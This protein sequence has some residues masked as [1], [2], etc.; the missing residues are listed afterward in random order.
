MRSS[1]LPP[2]KT[3]RVGMLRMPNIPGVIGL[4]ST[5]TLATLTRPSYSVARSSTIAA[6][7]LHGEHQ[8]AQKSTSTGTSR[9]EDHRRGHPVGAVGNDGERRLDL[10]GEHQLCAVVA[11]APVW[12]LAEPREVLTQTL[13]GRPGG[14]GARARRQEVGR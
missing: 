3:I 14:M 6:I 2:R 12:A 4:A 13:T 10:S 7:T 8:D 11:A 5:S 9:S 1:A